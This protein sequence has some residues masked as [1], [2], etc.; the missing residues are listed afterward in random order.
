MQWI[1]LLILSEEVDDVTLTITF[2][3][4]I[5]LLGKVTLNFPMTS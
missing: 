4:G 3:P 1:Y 2:I 5:W